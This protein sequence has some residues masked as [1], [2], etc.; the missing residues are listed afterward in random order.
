MELYWRAG[1][2]GSV[3]RAFPQQALSGKIIHFL[4]KC[5]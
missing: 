5:R 1:D 2:D 3:N 4:K